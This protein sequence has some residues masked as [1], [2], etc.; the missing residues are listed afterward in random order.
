[1]ED[2]STYTDLGEISLKLFKSKNLTVGELKKALEDVQ[3]ECTV[4]VTINSCCGC[5]KDCC[6]KEKEK[7]EQTTEKTEKEWKEDYTKVPPSFSEFVEKEGYMV[8]SPHKRVAVEAVLYPHIENSA[9]AKDLGL[10]VVLFLK[11][12][13]SNG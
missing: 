3:D 9:Q 10:E 12:E 11:K 7:E 8:I 6:S 2:T 1:M 4:K 13:K 5:G